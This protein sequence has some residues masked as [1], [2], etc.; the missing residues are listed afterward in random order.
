MAKDESRDNVSP[1][2]IEPGVTS[3]KEIRRYRQKGETVTLPSGMV[4]RRRRVH[5][6]DLMKQG[7]L[8][9]PLNGLASDLINAGKRGL[10][11]EDVVQYVDVVNLVVKAAVVE[12]PVGDEPSDT[13]L[14]VDE[15]D[16]LDRLAIFNDSNVAMRPLRKFRPEQA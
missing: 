14:G 1:L 7:G 3:I 2:K 10:T 9:A 4:V 5:L 16:M 11:E 6:M 8:P 13:Q 15:L 12:P